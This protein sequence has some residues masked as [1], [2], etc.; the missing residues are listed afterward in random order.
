MVDALNG[1]RGSGTGIPSWCDGIV[2]VLQ[3]S[4][5]G[6]RL[7]PGSRHTPTRRAHVGPAVCRRVPRHRADQAPM[8][9]TNHLRR[10]TAGD[11][12]AR[13]LPAERDRAQFQCCAGLNSGPPGFFLLYAIWRV[14][15]PGGCAQ[16][17]LVS[18]VSGWAPI[19]SRPASSRKR[20]RRKESAWI[21]ST[22]VIV[23]TTSSATTGPTVVPTRR[24]G[25]MTRVPTGSNAA[26]RSDPEPASR[27]D[28]CPCCGRPYP[29]RASI[30]R[31]RAA[32]VGSRDPSQ[33]TVKPDTGFSTC[34]R[35]RQRSYPW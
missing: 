27:A 26:M 4:T 33:P 9:R 19:L 29:A 28:V 13:D 7:S 6:W 14:N 17:L 24:P 1:L 16:E 12:L 18:A 2:T 11:W 8:R 31:D 23:L 21:H 25:S 35:S 5:A 15:D 32:R 10:F 34:A 22:R 3:Q 30:A 20:A